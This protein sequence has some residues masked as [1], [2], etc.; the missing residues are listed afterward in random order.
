MTDNPQTD[1]L[2]IGG[3]PVGLLIGY[4]LARQGVGTIVVEQH[5]KVQQP[6]YGRAC[7]LHPR[8]LEMLDQLD[9]L[10]DLNQIGYI[11]RNSVTWKDGKRI[12]SRGWHLMFDRM[13]GTFMDYCLNLR[14]RYSEDVIREAYIHAGGQLHMGWKLEDFSLYLSQNTDFKVTGTICRVGADNERVTINS[15]FIIGADGGHSTVRKLAGIQAQGD[16]TSFK[17]IRIDGEFKTNMPDDDVGFASI[18]SKSHGNVLWAQ[19]DH[20]V[21][22]IGFAATPEML[23]RYGGSLTEE[24][25]VAEAVKA[26]EPFT[27]E[28]EKVEWWTLYN[29]NQQLA[30]TYL[31]NE[32][33]LLAGDAC[34]IHS[35]AGA[36]GMNT[37]VHDAVNLAWKLNGVIKGWYKPE[38]LQTYEDERRT[39]AQYL[40]KLDKTISA[41]VFGTVPEEHKGLSLDAN[42]LW[43]KITSDSMLFNIGLGVSYQENLFNK[44]PLTGMISAGHRAPDSL[45]MAPGSR[46][47]AR[48][49]QFTKNTGQ[50]PILVFAGQP[51]VTKEKLTLAVVGLLK[52]QS[53]L[54]KGMVRFLTLIAGSFGGGN[55]LFGTPRI[56][57]FYFDPEYSAHGRYA[58]STTQG[59]VVVLRPDGILGYATTLDDT[60]SIGAFFAGFIRSS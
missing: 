48:L 36:Q 54:P 53:T 4:S 43:T 2:I 22:R 40:I 26:I 57:R 37:G 56:G 23:A 15:Q 44:Y 7:T 9:L 28:I 21:K 24:Q 8:T 42:E 52:L 19:L 20:G 13:D 11:C 49:Y 46:V 6:M 16:R 45:L 33:V 55:S 32:R 58:I 3:G 31:A 60:T 14:Q 59:A 50:W 1:V 27:L 35:S 47:P 30:D 39:A 34:H 12:T 5:E 38:A 17:L 29:V 41:T 25:A 18:E 51:A 10:D